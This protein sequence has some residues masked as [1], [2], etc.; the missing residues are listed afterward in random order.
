MLSLHFSIHNWLNKRRR[1]YLL[2]D[3]AIVP[4]P[5][6]GLYVDY[7]RTSNGDRPGGFAGSVRGS[8]AMA[9][10]GNTQYVISRL[11]A[12]ES[13]FIRRVARFQLLGSAAATDW[14]HRLNN[15]R[16]I[17]VENGA[18]SV[19]LPAQ[20]YTHT[21]MDSHTRKKSDVLDALLPIDS[22]MSGSCWC[23]CGCLFQTTTSTT[24]TLK[25]VRPCTGFEQLLL[26]AVADEAI[27][28]RRTIGRFR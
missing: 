21:L 3:D 9:A 27:W 17:F 12:Y 8:L 19:L 25:T 7:S 22:M 16:V 13:R 23:C 1:P 20:K 26:L 6:R 14:S 10:D 24:M 2:A 18:P 15:R 28:Y 4:L 5:G 11:S